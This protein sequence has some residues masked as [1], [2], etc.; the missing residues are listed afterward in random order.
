MHIPQAYTRLL[1]DVFQGK[2]AAFVRED[3]LRASWEIFTPLLHAIE[4]KDQYGKPLPYEFGSRGPLESDAL[5]AKHGYVYHEG[6]YTYT[7]STTAMAK[8]HSHL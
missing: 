3:E 4:K 8:H 5:S 1:L 6:A 2:Q 7:R